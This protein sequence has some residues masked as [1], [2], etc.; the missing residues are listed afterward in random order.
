MVRSIPISSQ[1]RTG[2]AGLE[3]FEGI[4]YCIYAHIVGGSDIVQKYVD[5]AYGWSLIE[6]VKTPMRLQKGFQSHWLNSISDLNLPIILIRGRI[7]STKAEAS[8]LLTQ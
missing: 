6:D 4:R 7:S 1:K 3:N 8:H 2:L 5:V